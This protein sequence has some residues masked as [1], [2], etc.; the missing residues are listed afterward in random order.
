[1]HSSLRTQILGWALL[2]A[3]IIA[4]PVGI[5]YHAGTSG[6]DKEAHK[7][8]KGWSSLF[9][10]RK[11][12][13]VL[14]LYG[15]ITDDDEGSSFF[16]HVDTAGW[17]KRKLRKAVDQ[18]NVKAV[19][20]RINSPGGTVG[21]SQEVYDAIKAARAKGKIIA[22]SMG[23][24]TASGGYYIASA[25][26]RIF[27][28][29]GTLTGSIGVIMHLLNWQETEKKIGL[30]PN[31]IKSG[32]F[33][34]IG[35]P[36]RPM[37]A[38]EKDLLQNIIMDSY[39]QFVSAVADGRKMDKEQ[40]KK[41]ADGRIYSGRQAV[42]VKLVDELGSYDDTLAWLQKTCKDKFHLQND[43]PVDDGSSSYS[44]LSQLLGGSTESSLSLPLQSGKASDLLKG[45]IPMSAD[46]QYSKV[47]LWILQ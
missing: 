45:I 40:V 47:P 12:I 27:A 16:P 24:I 28:N 10:N 35:S 25:A 2:L 19:L 42:K 29:P 39:D 46:P 38:E 21:M 9:T 6:A 33:K 32:A 17:V 36:D 26:D 1:M 31:V 3:C 14:R 13:M 20:L 34:D 41:L 11:H 22:V 15:P 30:A 4:I 37:S 5:F 44:L 43:L 18:D 7:G 8:E 23:D